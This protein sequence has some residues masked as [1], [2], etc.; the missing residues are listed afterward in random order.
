LL[1]VEA[2]PPPPELPITMPTTAATTATTTMC[3]VRHDRRSLMCKAPGAGVPV[4]ADV[5]QALD[6]AMTDDVGSIGPEVTD[7][8]WGTS[9]R[10]VKR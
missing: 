1:F 2:E 3:H 8:A 10:S 7:Q 4:A 6:V 9:R 5:S